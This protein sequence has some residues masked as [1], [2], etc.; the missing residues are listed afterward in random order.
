MRERSSSK[1]YEYVKCIIDNIKV[2]QGFEW[3]MWNV[4]KN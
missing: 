2:M 4:K 1:Y 3:M